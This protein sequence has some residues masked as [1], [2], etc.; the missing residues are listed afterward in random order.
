MILSDTSVKRPILAFVV[1]TLLLAFGLIS[2]ER[3]SLREYPNIDPPIV[4]IDTKYL[5]ASATVVENRITKLI[6]NRISGVNGIKYISSTSEDG[7]SKITVEFSLERDIDAAANDLRDRVS[8]VL[9]NLPEQADPPEVEKADGD[10]SVIMWFNLASDRLDVT[11]LTDYAER[12]VVDQFSVLDGVARVRVGGGQSYALRIWLDPLKMAS[13]GITTTNVESRLREANVE[14]PAGNLQGKNTMLTVQVQKPFSTVEQIE[15]LVIDSQNT[16]QIRLKEIARVQLG[17]I[18][19]RRAFRGNGVPMVGVGIIKQSTAN[20]LTVAKLAKVKK[21]QVNRMLPAGMSLEDS[22]DASIFVASA[23]NEVYKTLFIALALVAL[24]MLVF[25]RSLKAAIIP[26]V[27][28]PISILATFWLLY[29]FGFTINLLTLLALVLA[30]G[31]VVDDAI[32]VLEN[33]QRHI[34]HG[35]HPLSSAYLGAR[36]V[37]FAV[38]ATTLVLISVFMPIGF[39]EGNIGRLFTEFAVTLSVAVILSSWV[40]LTLSPALASKILSSNQTKQR[41]SHS[42][43]GLKRIFGKLLKTNLRYPWIIFSILVA[44]IAALVWQAPKV[45]QELVPKEDRGAFF[46]SVKGPE[47]ASFEYMNQYMEEIERRL[48]PWIEQG[49]VKRLLIR[50]PRS[51]GNSQVFNTGFAIIVLEDW[52]KRP[53]AYKMMADVRE[54]LKDLTGV[55]AF[56]IMRSGIGGRISKPVQFV[57]SGNSYEELA[58]W[59]QIMDK[60]LAE[61]NPGLLGGDWDYDPS[62]P[63]LKIHIDYDQADVLGIDQKTLSETLQVLL[64]SK[65][66]TTF[67]F[68]GEEIDILLEAEHKELQAPHDLNNIYLQSDS[69]DMISLGQ[70]VSF[71]QFAAP[72]TLNR[73]NRMRS[74]T[75]SANLDEGLPL[76]QALEHLEMLVKQ[77]LP[78]HAIISYKGQSL[79]FQESSSN[80]TFTFMFALSVIFLVLAAQFE[81]FKSP[82]VI[83]LGVPLALAGGLIAMLVH[84]ISLNIFSQIA[85]ILLLGLATKNG[86]LIVEFANQLRDKGKSLYHALIQATQQRLRPIL[87]TTITTCAGAVP[88]IFSSG[89]GAETRQILGYILIW[90]VAFSTLLSLFLIPALYA[91]IA[92]HTHTPQYTTQRLNRIL[93]SEKKSLPSNE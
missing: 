14:L 46:V 37:G 43:R 59:Q 47:G 87:M 20:T 68:K 88:L 16:S 75:Y 10:E 85:L 30:I 29:Q 17:A 44:L 23:V 9:D 34:E 76:A 67:P 77:E 61:N 57:V 70:I 79:E 56:P 38:I 26:L 11:E 31:L 54:R 74:I 52:S 63:Q 86:I 84:E 2:F 41:S 5:G 24:V 19:T 58:Q 12:Y 51:F 82:L 91:L 80:M 48:S 3:M 73:Y 93:K 60:A 36:Q 83:M 1:S 39:L 25:L 33:I 40:A 62:K 27:T 45:P 6:E 71:E 35:H 32:V 90:G 49:Y 8:K 69:G 72:S 64:G 22:Y 78:S 50:T 92:K 28:L 66:V 42:N 15:N 7:R 18:E 89:A 4:T 81:S 21:E 65:T 55:K 53:N 13:Y